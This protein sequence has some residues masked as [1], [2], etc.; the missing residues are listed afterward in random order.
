MITSVMISAT[1]NIIPKYKNMD[2]SFRFAVGLKVA[3]FINDT[4]I[5]V[6]E[7]YIMTVL[8]IFD[9]LQTCYKCYYKNDH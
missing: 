7:L 5:T 4:I 3:Y 6:T 2:L 1:V 9:N 8:F